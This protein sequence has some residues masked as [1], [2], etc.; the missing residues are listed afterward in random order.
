MM[1]ITAKIHSG[2]MRGALMASFLF[3]LLPSSA[4]NKRQ[5]GGLRKTR[6]S[7]YTE[8]KVRN[9]AENIRSYA[10]A[11]QQKDAILKRA[12][13]YLADFNND[14]RQIWSLAPSQEIPRSFAVN[15]L[16]GCLVCGTAINRYGNYSYLYD[17]HDIDWKLTC[18]HCHVTFPTNDFKAYYEGGLERDGKFSRSKARETNDKLIK[19]GKRGN[20][21]NLYTINGISPRRITELKA[22]GVSDDIIHKITTDPKWGVDDGMGYHFNPADKEK[23]GNPYTYVAYYS[24]WVIWY[25]HI[26]PMLQDLSQAYMFTRYSDDAAERADAQHYADAAIVLLDRVAD[27]YPEMRV[28]V[29]PRNDYYGFPNSG[30]HWGTPNSAGRI[31]GS[32]WEN[33]IIKSIMFSYDAVFPA[34][35]NLSDK[36]KNVL[37]EMSGVS[38][39]GNSESIKRNFENGV[40]MEIPKAYADG[41]LQ[42][43]PGM[44]QSTLALAA[45]MMDHN[46]ET[47]DWLNTVYR[48]GRCDWHDIGKK[49]A[50]NVMHYMS[51]RIDRDGEGDEVSIGYNAGW[52]ENWL[53][54]AKALDGYT[55]PDG[56]ILKGNIDPDLLNNIRYK[57]LFFT[58]PLL[59]TN[60]YSAHIGDTGWTGQ[61]YEPS[62]D[63]NDLIYGYSKYHS[64]YIAQV[65][66]LLKNGKTDGIHSDIFT[67]NP[68]S[69]QA[70]IIAA[71]NKYGE[72][73][74]PSENRTAYGLAM[75]RDSL[76]TLWMYYGDRC[77]S[78]NHADP[79]NIGY[80][81]YGLDLMP[82]FGY[83][84]TLGSVKNPEHQWDKSTPAHNTVSYDALGY[85]GHIVGYG[86]PLHFDD[87]KNVQLIQVRSKKVQNGGTHFF[88]DYCRTTAMIRIND[89]DSYMVDFFH[90]DCPKGYT[91]NFHTAEVDAAATQYGNLLENTETKP[92]TYDENTLR[93]VR[94]FN[95]AGKSFSIDW[96]VL[97]TWNV[98]GK[99]K[100]GKTDVHFKITMPSSYNKIR[101]GEAVPPTNVPDNPSWVPVL[102]VSDKDVTDFTAVMEGYRTD[103]K[104]ASVEFVKVKDG[105]AIA[106][107]TKVRAIKVT[108]TDGR[109]DYIV[110]SLDRNKTYKI[111]GKFKFKGFFAVY[112]LDAKGKNL[113]SYINDGTV[114]NRKSYRDRASG[115][116]VDATDTLTDKNY[117]VVKMDNDMNA[118]LLKGTF[119]Y[120]NNDDIPDTE[121]QEPV[122]KY[123]AVYPIVSATKQTDGSYK[124]FLGDSSVVRGLKDL[125]DYSKGYLRD[126]NIGATFYIPFSHE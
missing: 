50:G 22:A 47:V 36:A 67:K 116:V 117:I 3:T 13:Q 21:V 26:M 37:T 6:S 119:I 45:V 89:N 51:D 63:V 29:F 35:D 68:E 24:H 95:A 28:D 83:P 104:L 15:S 62:S 82:D 33:T 79:L 81:A 14:Y 11:S 27:V 31:V 114:L 5:D 92:V 86:K 34:I 98:Y 93:N 126:F 10:W 69:V 97:D 91:Y 19:K 110:N 42:G 99:G 88:N 59:L 107:T 76:R 125:N 75:M 87:G 38:D 64:P 101:I 112:S 58:N 66:Y 30:S 1:T 74:Q 25:W 9:A 102:M 39:K 48:N 78:H 32:I 20:L 72:L 41:D 120:V 71:V 40:L 49:D 43:N 80:I 77:A 16:S 44:H 54:I 65:I 46:P 12:K 111:D 90:V 8:E 100:K 94:A 55:I 123:N 113:M 53:T 115:T 124:L 60:K 57:K 52:L 109:V 105:K 108:L 2:F 4:E 121:N 103:S 23:Y 17:K 56:Q 85:M 7:F 84:N 122:M 106:D 118:D 73:N 18:P 61:P 96:N 70:D